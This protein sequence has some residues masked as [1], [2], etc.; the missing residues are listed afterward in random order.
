[1]KERTTAKFVF[2]IRENSNP[3][4]RAGTN[5]SNTKRT[6]FEHISSKFAKNSPLRVVFSSLFSVFGYPD[7]TQSLVFDVLFQ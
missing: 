3:W 5:I 4:Q 2:E 1:M 6:D 7:E